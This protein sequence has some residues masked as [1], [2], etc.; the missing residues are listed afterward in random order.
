MD[1]LSSQGERM[2][3]YQFARDNPVYFAHLFVSYLKQVC[4]STL[5]ESAYFKIAIT[6]PEHI[7]SSNEVRKI[8]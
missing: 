4:L 7:E 2:W 8:G 1:A 5:R 6:N 3:D